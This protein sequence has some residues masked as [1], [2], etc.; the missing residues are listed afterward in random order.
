MHRLDCLNDGMEMIKHRYF[1]SISYL[2][3]AFKK[4]NLLN[5]RESELNGTKIK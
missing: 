3:S 2:N 1:F 4:K 5:Y